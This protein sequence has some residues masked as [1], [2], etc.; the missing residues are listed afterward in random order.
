MERLAAEG[1][2]LAHVGEAVLF[3]PG[4]V[5]GDVVEVQVNKRKGTA[6]EGYVTAWEELSPLR[7]EAPC[8][9]F[10]HCGGCQWQ[11]LPYEL[12]LEAKEEQVREQLRRLGG[13]E[14]PELEPILGADPTLYYRNKLEFTFSP[15][16][17]ITESGQ[18]EAGFPMA[19]GFHVPRR[20]DRVLDIEEC[21][22][23]PEPSNA[24]RNAVRDFALAKGYSFYDPKVQQGWLRNLMV[25]VAT[26]GEV[27]ILLVVAYED[28]PRR[29]ELLEHIAERFPDVTSLLYCINPKVNDTIYDLEVH[30]YRGR[31]YIEEQLGDLRFSIGPKS[32]YQTNSRQAE[33]LYAKV[34]EMARIKPTDAVYDLYTGTGTI[35]LY[36]ARHAARV[37]G[38]ETVPEAVED[39]W[40][41]AERN[42]LTNVDFYAGDVLRMLDEDF[43]QRHGRP[44][45]LI[46]DPPR[47]GMH[48]GVID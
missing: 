16:G 19:L 33:R 5:P 13:V 11:M 8:R 10:A 46:T 1:K 45:V 35:A 31:D 39:A 28:E 15:R 43:L 6:W 23:E 12:Q 17:W 48:P 34:L 47:A 26:T 27:M 41:N 21:L 44:D 18:E 20:F 22:L 7:V 29:V 9:H 14:V 30:A 24:L 4:T 37:V 2:S 3:V 36:V 38:V 40:L 32:F 25:R 42:G